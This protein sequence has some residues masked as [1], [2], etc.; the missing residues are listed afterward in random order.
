VKIGVQLPEV[1]RVVRWDELRRMAVLAEDVGLDS[2]WVGDH[3]LYRDAR[4]ERGP[5][6]AWTQLAAI[7]AVTTRVQIG[8]LVA[9]LPFHPPAMIAKLAATV[10]EISGGRLV[11]GVG[12]GWNDVEFRALGLPFDGRVARFEEA[13]TIVRRL[14]DGD[15]VTVH[16]EHHSV[17]DCILL[18]QP[19]R[20]PVMIGS[21]G[22]RMLQIS[23]P[24][25]AAWNA[26]FTEFSNRP[27]EVPS[28]LARV[29]AACERAGRDPATLEKTLAVLLDFG[30]GEPRNHSINP[31]RGSREEMADA[32]RAIAAA[33]VDGVQ[34]VLDP[35]TEETIG[36][37]AEVARLVR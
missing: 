11:L 6:E 1:E 20:V 4:G 31:I 33:G 36:A 16:G 10:A 26:W 23:L 19:P 5:W 37:A 7:A 8:P 32:L 35:I 29:D 12:A 30:S 28:L 13:F 22:A 34:L 18:P 21:V 9:A 17:E 3:F 14:L 2:V 27:E 25:V 15:K 24:H